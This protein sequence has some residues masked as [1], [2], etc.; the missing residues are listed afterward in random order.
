MT[1]AYLW[2]GY[3]WPHKVE[4]H[5]GPVGVEDY[6]FQGLA[7]RTEPTLS[8]WRGLAKLSAVN[9]RIDGRPVILAHRSG[10]LKHPGRTPFGTPVA[11]LA[12]EGHDM[13]AA[14]CGL[15]GFNI[16]KC[17]CRMEGAPAGAR[18]RPTHRGG[19]S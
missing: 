5:G 17:P 13:L 2:R 6:P 7:I 9:A 4:G 14:P 8:Y 18:A 11:E 15:C 12:R 3:P 1:D 16:A 19:G 10:D